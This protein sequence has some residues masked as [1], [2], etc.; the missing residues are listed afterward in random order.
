MD[1]TKLETALT[2]AKEHG[3]EMIEVD[4]VKI[5]LPNKKTIEPIASGLDDAQILNADDN[6]GYTDEEILYWATPYFDELQDLKN[7]KKQLA[8]LHE[9]VNGNGD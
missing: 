2:F 9:E 8:Q 5:I 4:G 3:L 6:F 1:R 7:Q